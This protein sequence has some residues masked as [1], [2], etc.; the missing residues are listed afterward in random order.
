VI[1]VLGGLGAAAAWAVSMLCSSRS[2]RMMEP[3][4]VVAWVMAIGLVL[5]A[6]I[7][8]LHGVPS[9]LTGSAAGWLA[10]AGAGNVAGL[11]LTYAALRIGQVALVVPLT[12]TEGAI[13]AVIALL[14][15]ETLQ[16]AVDVTLAV[17]VLGVV[18]SSLPTAEADHASGVAGRLRHT[19]AAVLAL[20]AAL[21]FGA[22]LYATARAGGEVSSAWVVLAARVIGT[23]ALAL[24]LALT[25]RLRLP[26][27]AVPLVLAAAVGEVAGFFSF[28]VASRHGIAIA[29]V[30]SSQFASLAAIGAYWLFGERLTRIQLAGVCTV[31]LGVAAL[32]ALRA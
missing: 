26:R 19:R 9:H 13:A 32:S 20:I 17:I 23:V 8:L 28:I 2:S 24:P 11:I 1:A 29:A 30:V 21:S 7:A 31:I 10:L 5:T 22:S 14:A 18:L 6:P 27:R 3:V 4:A 12:S 15:G 16:P 25:G